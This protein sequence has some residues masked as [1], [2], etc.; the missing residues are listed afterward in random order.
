VFDNDN[1]RAQ[2]NSLHDFTGDPA[3]LYSAVKST[4]NI[5]LKR[6]ITTNEDIDKALSGEHPTSNHTYSSP[7]CPAQKIKNK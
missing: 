1:L 3:A 5:H 7:T 2:L 6:A 4:G